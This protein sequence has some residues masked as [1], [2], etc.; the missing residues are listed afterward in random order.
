M[1]PSHLSATLLSVGFILRGALHWHLL[2]EVDHVVNYAVEEAV[3]RIENVT[4]KSPVCPASP[5]P[6]DF[7][8]C[9]DCVC[10]ACVRPAPSPCPP[11]D[12]ADVAD[13]IDLHS[14]RPDECNSFL[15]GFGAGVA[16]TT[17]LV[18]GYSASRREAP[19]RRSHGDGGHGRR[20]PGR[21]GTVSEPRGVLR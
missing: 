6:I 12:W 16:L 2:S 3:E 17:F 14:K 10:P 4:A 19:L 20:A 5:G 15:I 18:A 1:L 7:P 8:D 11:I 21:S 13:Q 9:P